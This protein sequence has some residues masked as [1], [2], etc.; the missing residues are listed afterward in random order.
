M[1][2]ATASQA[3][4][5][6]AYA[7]GACGPVDVDPPDVLQKLLQRRGVL[8][9][10]PDTVRVPQDE[11]LLLYW[12]RRTPNLLAKARLSHHCPTLDPCAA[13]I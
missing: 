6:I 12:S 10:Q 5:P 11:G 3:H 9:H 1:A 7:R 13:K 4:R 8:G 2:C